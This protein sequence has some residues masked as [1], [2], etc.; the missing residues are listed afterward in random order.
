MLIDSS[1]SALGEPRAEK[2]GVDG[3]W[4]GVGWTGRQRQKAL[5]ARGTVALLGILTPG[6]LAPSSFLF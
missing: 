6:L 1:S 4:L 2:G 3:S 5:K